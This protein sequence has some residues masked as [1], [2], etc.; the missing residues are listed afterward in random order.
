MNNYNGKQISELSI[1]LRD[2]VLCVCNGY[3]ESRLG[4]GSE[5]EGAARQKCME[6][7]MYAQ[8]QEGSPP[9]ITVYTCRQQQQQSEKFIN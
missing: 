7:M 3:H 2:G 8:L 5:L 9:I 4:L 6:Y 1:K